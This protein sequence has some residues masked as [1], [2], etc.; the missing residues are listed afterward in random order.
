MLGRKSCGGAHPGFGEYALGGALSDYQRYQF[1]EI[2]THYALA[3]V[4]IATDNDAAGE[5]Y[6]TFFWRLRPDAVRA[7]PPGSCK[8]WNEVCKR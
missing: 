6:A 3:R 8:D 2:L 5:A 4:L 7:C 1:T